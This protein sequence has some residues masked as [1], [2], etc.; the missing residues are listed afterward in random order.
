[1]IGRRIGQYEIVA[2]IGAGGMGTVYRAR[3]ISL[4]RDVA[5]KILPS[6]LALDPTGLERFQREAMSVAQLAHPNIVQVHDIGEDNGVHFIAM[7]YVR[8]RTA[9]EM[10]KAEGPLAF[11]KA[12]EI[13]APVAAALGVAHKAGILHRDVKPSNILVSEAGFAKLA[14]FGVAGLMQP[15]EGERLT[16]TG[17]AVG[18]PYYM[19][20]EQVR[21]REALDGAGDV[22]SLGVVLYELLSGAHPFGDATPTEAIAKQMHEPFPPIRRYRPDIPMNWNKCWHDV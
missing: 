8:G 5:L 22:Y 16:M 20:P 6:H 3:Q 13:C 15:P 12:L 4:N 1:M 21:G 14:D 10:L 19:S 9:A 18:T 17:A 11:R 7:E 2:E